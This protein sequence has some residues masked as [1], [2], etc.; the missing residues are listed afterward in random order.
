MIIEFSIVPAERVLTSRF[1]RAR[2]TYLARQPVD[3]REYHVELIIHLGK[4]IIYVGE[5]NTHLGKL[6]VHLTTEL[7]DLQR[8]LANLVGCQLDTAIYPS[9]FPEK[10][11]FRN[12]LIQQFLLGF[13][14]FFFDCVIVFLRVIHH[15]TM[16]FADKSIPYRKY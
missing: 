2:I 15:I 3:G 10:L 6:P 7:L 13:Q 9:Y 11:R 8:V 4:P 1:F 16:I 12:E 5:P 14:E